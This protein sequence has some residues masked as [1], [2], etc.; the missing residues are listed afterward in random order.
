MWATFIIQNAQNMQHL[1]STFNTTV[2][3]KDTVRSLR[4]ES[5]ACFP[6]T[7]QERREGA[8]L[9]HVMS[10]R[11]MMRHSLANIPDHVVHSKS[12]YMSSQSP[13]ASGHVGMAEFLTY[14]FNSFILTLDRFK[15]LAS[16]GVSHHVTLVLLAN[17][18]GHGMGRFAWVY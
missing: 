8:L 14:P 16:C 11:R 6:R 1:P 4:E 18:I 10:V 15:L 13:D 17:S 9:C 2:N 3:M 5:E 7:S 12:G